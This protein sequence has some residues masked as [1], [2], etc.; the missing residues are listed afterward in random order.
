MLDRGKFEGILYWLLFSK[1]RLKLRKLVDNQTYKKVKLTLS[2]TE[3]FYKHFFLS[4]IGEL[5]AKQ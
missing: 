2:N 3:N 1:Q 5:C 4:S